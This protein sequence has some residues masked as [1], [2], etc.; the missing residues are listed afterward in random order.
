MPRVT[1]LQPA[2]SAAAVTPS[3]ELAVAPSSVVAASGESGCD[4]GPTS[5]TGPRLNLGSEPVADGPADSVSGPL[6]PATS[7]AVNAARIRFFMGEL[8]SAFL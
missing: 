3:E 2:T 5:L 1:E 8:L 6:Q 4:G 7:M